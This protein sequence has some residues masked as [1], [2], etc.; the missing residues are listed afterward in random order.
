[1]TTVIDV[2]MMSSTFRCAEVL[3]FAVTDCPLCDTLV[4]ITLKS[5]VKLFSTRDNKVGETA[6]NRFNITA[7]TG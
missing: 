7:K 3:F 4:C 5:G 2:I 1:M 6:T